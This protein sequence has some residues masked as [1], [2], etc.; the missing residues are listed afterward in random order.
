MF[1]SNFFPAY[2]FA[3]F[4]LQDLKKSKCGSIIFISSIAA[5]TK[6]TAN[7]GFA[8][9]KYEIN[10]FAK[11][12]ALK[13]AKE[14]I[15]VNVLAPGNIYIKNGNWDLKMK[16][17]GIKILKYIKNNVPM[18]RFGYPEEIANLCTFLTSK[19]SKFITGQVIAVDGGQSLKK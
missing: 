12:L 3:N 1:R 19:K 6:T 8:K 17:N 18:R 14:N 9:A 4:F 7:S 13:L 10:K 15:N 16:S 5:I 2:K 11:K